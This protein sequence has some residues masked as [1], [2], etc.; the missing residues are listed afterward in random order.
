MGVT[1]DRP[2]TGLCPAPTKE[3]ICAIIVTYFPDAQFEERLNRIHAQVGRTLIVDNTGAEVPSAALQTVDTAGIEIIRNKENVGIGEA[4]NQG[5]ARAIELGYAWTITFDQDSW[6]RPELVDVLAGIYQQQPKP[7]LVGIIGCNIEDENTHVSPNK[8]RDDGLMFSEIGVV[9][10]SGSLM[11]T[12]IFT[13]AGPFRSDFFI[14]F[15]DIEYCLRLRKLGYKV[16]T[17]KAPLMVHALG[18]ATPFN[19]ESR[20]G[21]LALVLTNRSPLRRYYMTRNAILVAKIYFS[22]APG[23]GIRNLASVF[24][25]ALLKIPLEKNARIR[26]IGATI[27]GTFDALRSKTGKAR[28]GWLAE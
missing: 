3:N 15:V 23:W 13:L 14:D 22:F 25:F 7:E 5:W 17:S 21:T 11:S 19:F 10:T 24:G 26:K 2:A 1:E 18:A 9:I 27:Y 8:Y 12:T 20:F 16:L 28:A 4:L 6:V